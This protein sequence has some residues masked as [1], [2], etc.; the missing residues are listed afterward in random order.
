VGKDACLIGRWQSE[1][2]FMEHS[3][4]IRHA[5]RFTALKP[6]EHAQAVAETLTPE[7]CVFI[8]TRRRD[9]V[10]NPRYARTLGAL[11]QDYFRNAM[12][13]IGEI[14]SQRRLR[15]FFGGDDI[16]WCRQAFHDVPNAVFLNADLSQ[17]GYW[18]HLWLLS[19]FK[20]GI[21]CNGTYAWWGAWL[22]EK[23]GSVII[24]P[25]QWSR[26]PEEQPEDI[27]PARWH[28]L[29]SSFEPLG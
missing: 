6:T 22:G 10:T 17:K 23:Q 19:Q 12:R 27:I 13:Y 2:F 28:Q 3:S 14:L 21:I 11:D 25:K 26:T 15:F 7:D 4:V 8:Q 5:F 29:D 20:H 1:S 18:S 9:Y 16:N 24:A